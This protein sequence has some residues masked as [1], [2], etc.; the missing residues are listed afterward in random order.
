M[1]LINDGTLLQIAWFAN[2]QNNVFVAGT[3]HTLLRQCSEH[4]RWRKTCGE[5]QLLPLS[6]IRAPLCW[7]SSSAEI[8]AL[9][10]YHL[11]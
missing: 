5:L 9:S 11:R 1:A 8:V 10:P 7:A 4:G 6:A 3:L 2:I